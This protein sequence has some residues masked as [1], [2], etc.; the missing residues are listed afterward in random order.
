[1]FAFGMLSALWH[2]R[3][4]GEGQVVD[5]AIVDGVMTLMTALYGRYA[6]GVFT[7]E[8]EG[9]GSYAAPHFSGVYKCADGGFVAVCAFEPK[10]YAEL[11][12]LVGV[13]DDPDFSDQFDA[14]RWPALKAKLAERIARRTRDEW[15]ELTQ[16]RDACI[17]PV[18]SMT[19][20]LRHPHNV[21]REAFTDVAGMT[22]P[23]PSPR[24]SVTPA[25]VR[26][27][28]PRP[29]ANNREGLLRWGVAEEDIARLYADGALRDP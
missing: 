18:L 14:S 3:E 20:A 5:A 28:P 29:G 11:L 13:D 10:F 27:P 16:G 19:E 21:A 23:S 22:L 4:T 2:A 12:R 6:E 7:G 24:L 25:A 8:R 15:G 1:M 26:R 9:P 17:A